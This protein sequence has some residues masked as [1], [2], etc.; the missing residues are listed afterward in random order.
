MLNQEGYQMLMHQI[1][2]SIQLEALKRRI[3][4][5][6]LANQIKAKQ[7]RLAKLIIAKLQ[8]IQLQLKIYKE[9]H[10]K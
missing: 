5:L 3:F 10:N 8:T 7:L 6:L 9:K 4:L 1:K 2:W